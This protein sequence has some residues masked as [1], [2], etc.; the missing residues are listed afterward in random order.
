MATVYDF[1]EMWQGSQNPH[2]AWKQSPTPNKHMAAVGYISDAEEIFKASWLLF[3]HDGVAAFKFSERSPLPPN[4]AAKD[5]HGGR[6]T[7]FNVRQIRRINHHPVESDEDSTTESISDAENW[8][9]WNGCMDSP[10]DSEGDCAADDKSD[11][12]YN[13]R[14][15]DWEC[16]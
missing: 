1:L 7:I 5:L 6:A 11:I 9:K 10:H 15:Q 12:D 16:P 13:K 2:T 8:L 3:Q 14:I 4:W